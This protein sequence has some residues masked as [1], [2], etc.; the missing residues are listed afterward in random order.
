[1]NICLPE[2]SGK[3]Q[4]MTMWFSRLT[5][6]P[7]EAWTNKN[8]GLWWSDQ[9]PCSK[10][11]PSG[12]CPRCNMQFATGFYFHIGPWTKGVGV[13]S[14]NQ[15]LEKTT[16]SRFSSWYSCRTFLAIAESGKT[17]IMLSLKLSISFHSNKN[18]DIHLSLTMRQGHFIQ[19]KPF[20]NDNS[21]CL[22]WKIRRHERS[23]IR[24]YEKTIRG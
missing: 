2:P 12:A 1:M 23:D 3:L 22:M 4:H 10:N 15:L 6:I 19:V 7:F 16:K 9:R 14:F 11:S 18:T 8:K 13:R 21:R 5:S 24:Q 17:K 20:S